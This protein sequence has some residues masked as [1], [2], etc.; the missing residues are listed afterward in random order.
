MK[1]VK[2]DTFK[3]YGE[4]WTVLAVEEMSYR[5][6]SSSGAYGFISFEAYKAVKTSPPRTR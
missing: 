4:T 5:V 1:L 3:A 6:K 2:G